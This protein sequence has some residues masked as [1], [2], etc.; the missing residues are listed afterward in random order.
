[1]RFYS[2]LLVWERCG[3]TTDLSER[4]KVRVVGK[5]SESFKEGNQESLRH[6]SH[7]S[8]DVLKKIMLIF[9]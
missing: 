9:K 3:W 4:M 8:A 5:E 6:F 1:M 7:N 2:I